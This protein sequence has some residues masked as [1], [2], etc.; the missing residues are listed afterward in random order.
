MRVRTEVENWP[1]VRAECDLERESPVV[2]VPDQR[3]CVGLARSQRSDGQA[4]N[5]TRIGVIREECVRKRTV[6]AMYEWCEGCGLNCTVPTCA[7]E[8]RCHVCVCVCVCRDVSC[9]VVNR[10]NAPSE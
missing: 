7:P 6:E 1:L 5:A 8:K 3:V 10:C 2:E 4:L 9:V